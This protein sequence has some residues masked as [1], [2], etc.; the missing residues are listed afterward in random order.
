MQLV[1]VDVGDVVDQVDGPREPAEQQERRERAQRRLRLE[2]VLGQRE[3]REDQ[4]ILGPLAR[5]QRNGDG[6]EAQKLLI[7]SSSLS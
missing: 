3:R 1:L 7:A 6:G 4:Q 2:Q 5:P